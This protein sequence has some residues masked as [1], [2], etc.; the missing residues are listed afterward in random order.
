M[1]NKPEAQMRE[2]MRISLEKVCP[3]E[4]STFIL[5]AEE[6]SIITD[7]IIGM[8]ITFL[9]SKEQRGD[10]Y[11][12]K[13]RKGVDEEI[14]KIEQ[15]TD[16]LKSLFREMN[17]RTAD[18]FFDAGMSRETI[19]NICSQV[20]S[21]CRNIDTGSVPKTALPSP[22]DLAPGSIADFLAYGFKLLTGENATV[23]YKPIEGVQS[24]SY[25]VLVEEVFAAAEID[26]NAVYWAKGGKGRKRQQKKGSVL[27]LPPNGDPS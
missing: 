5:S 23:S 22:A 19:I 15:K 12:N 10:N 24:G 6:R 2:Q 4:N 1:T 26:A 18:L 8:V 20:A 27:P 9:S 21:V 11:L 7:A 13:G 3:R 25:L 17:V 14:A 16:E